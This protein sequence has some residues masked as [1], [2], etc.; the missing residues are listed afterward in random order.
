[1]LVHID[2][3]RRKNLIAI[4]ITKLL[5]G[6]GTNIFG[7]VYQVY[8]FELT[9]S[10]I[11]TGI[12]VSLGSVI[13]F[14]PMPLIGKLSDKFNRKLII[15]I[16]MPIYI[17]GLF[18]LI[19]ANPTT[20]YFAVLGIM[21]YFLGFTINN[22]NSQ[23]IVTESTTKSK[24]LIY[25]IMFFSYFLGTIGGSI[26]VVADSSLDARAYFE[27]FIGVLAFE[28][29]IYGILLSNKTQLLENE[30][31]IDKRVKKEN[32]WKKILRTKTLR[33]ILMFF[34]LDI[35][36][37]GLTLSIYVAGLKSY[38]NLT[39]EN[40]AIL[41]MGMNITNML[42]QIP[43]GRIT[44]K[45]GSKK[46][47]IL[48]QFF[49]IG[50]FIMNVLAVS[51]WSNNY[52]T[53]LLFILLVGHISLAISVVTFIPS[54]QMI[55]TNLDTQ[56]KG[57]SYGIIAFARGLGYIPTGYLGGLIVENLGYMTLFIFSFCGVIIEIIFLLRFFHHHPLSLE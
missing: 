56:R 26:L 57:E 36:V 47:L 51:L 38:Y 27:I 33:S 22:L 28:C 18:L 7:V 42:F 21:M 46:T 40:I 16:S 35:F 29:L 17:L 30:F 43:A 25:G 49:G 4:S 3:I 53:P 45:I 37:Y 24:G 9:N 13:Q 12:I 32:Q 11:I 1:M 2:K 10:L 52:G 50:F 20:L 54:E 5:H 55:L 39:V 19:I 48:S 31:S 34:T 23:F 41:S 14:L 8:L 6:F 44:D 15:I